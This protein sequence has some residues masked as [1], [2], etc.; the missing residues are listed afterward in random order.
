M[1]DII[2]ING[3]RPG[4]PEP[5]PEAPVDHIDIVAA[6]SR[7]VM[8]EASAAI[9]ITFNDGG[10]FALFQSNTD[11]RDQSLAAARLLHLMNR[12]LDQL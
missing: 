12:N 2:G 3:K 6:K 11:A 4:D 7:E 9:L 8:P 10:A 5:K 1:A